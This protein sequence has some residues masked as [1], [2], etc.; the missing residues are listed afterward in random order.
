MYN[1]MVNQLQNFK[2]QIQ[3]QAVPVS[4]FSVSKVTH[5]KIL[6]SADLDIDL[7]PVQE[8]ARV[9]NE[10]SNHKPHTSHLLTQTQF[11][12]PL[13]CDFEPDI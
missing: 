7:D 6:F 8:I 3:P 5:Q 1:Y 9:F 4:D 11:F 13:S 10:T 2:L 12:T